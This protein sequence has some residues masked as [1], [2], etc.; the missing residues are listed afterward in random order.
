MVLNLQEYMRRANDQLKKMEI[1]LTKDDLKLMEF[2]SMNQY[3]VKE[4]KKV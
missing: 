2:I 1:T 3:I 4:A